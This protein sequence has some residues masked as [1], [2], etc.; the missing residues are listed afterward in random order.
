MVILGIIIG[1]VI[2]SQFGT[3]GS[4]I[5]TWIPE[6]E[7]QSN[8]FKIVLVSGSII[9]LGLVSSYYLFRKSSNQ[10]IQK[11]KLLILGFLEGIKAIL[12][13]ENAT[14]FI[15]HTLFIWLMYFCMF[16]LCFFSLPQ[17]ANVPFSGI[18]AAFV[19]G[20]LS[21]IFVQGG[22]GVYPAA[23]MEVLILYGISR[24]SSLALG[25]II[26]TSQTTMI[27]ILGIISLLLMPKFNSKYK[28]NAE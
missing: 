1:L 19:M 14:K 20:G 23:I 2:F 4:L 26:W 12:K 3:L 7:D 9:C 27:L 10:F 13:M 18:L 8:L 21:I 11:L 16:Y 25:W 22:I 5:N 6:K 17:T 28:Q 24:P 15:L